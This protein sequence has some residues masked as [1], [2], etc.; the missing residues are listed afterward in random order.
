MNAIDI[1]GSTVTVG[2]M[3]LNASTKL[4]VSGL[5][6]RVLDKDHFGKDDALGSAFTNKLGVFRATFDKSAFMEGNRDQDPDLYF[7]VFFDGTHIHSTKDNVLRNVTAQ[8]APIV[9]EVAIPSKMVPALT[10][11]PIHSDELEADVAFSY[12]EDYDG[13]DS[14]ADAHVDSWEQIAAGCEYIA[15]GQGGKVAVVHA[16]SGLI[17]ERATAAEP[18]K[19]IGGPAWEITYG[20]N[21]EGEDVLYAMLPDVDEPDLNT[22]QRYENNRWT[23][24]GGD[25]AVHIEVFGSTVCYASHDGEVFRYA[26]DDSKTESAWISMGGDAMKLFID[27]D[28]IYKID[29]AWA[30]RQWVDGTESMDGH[31]ALEHP[32]PV[33][34]FAATGL[35]LYLSIANEGDEIEIKRHKT[36]EWRP[37][38][39]DG[40]ELIAS[41]NTLWRVGADSHLYRWYQDGDQG[42][43]WQLEGDML[44]GDAVAAHGNLYCLFVDEVYCKHTGF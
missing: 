33:S 19:P 15:A 26:G 6:V 14:S 34:N 2:G 21:A 20:F 25:D 29:N 43:H 1:S 7:N 39:H 5:E 28:G 13:S 22:V 4:P 9:L 12:D 24:L 44:T 17:F 23:A 31:W 38:S 27:A 41:K 3:V 8:T 10:V 35:D 37:F 16:L 40:V 11:A 42:G 32:G 18:F 30:L 36:A